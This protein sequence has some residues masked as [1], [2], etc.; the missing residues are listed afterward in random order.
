LGDRIKVKFWEDTWVGE[1]SLKD[2]YLRLFSI[3]ECKEN[4]S[5]IKERRGRKPSV[6]I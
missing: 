3:S 1:R 4:T 2:T 6:H 5:R